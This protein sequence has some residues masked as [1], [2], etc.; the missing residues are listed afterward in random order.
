M[1]KDLRV[2]TI[3]AVA[4]ARLPD[5]IESFEHIQAITVS[6]RHEKPVKADRQTS[7]APGLHG[8]RR[9]E[10]AGPRGN[11]HALTVLAVHGR[12]HETG[13]GARKRAI[14]AIEQD[15]LDDGPLP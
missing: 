5:R 15:R 3:D 14:E 1:P 10:H 2:V 12:R 6:I 13:D 4:E 11:E 8:G 9:A 7:I